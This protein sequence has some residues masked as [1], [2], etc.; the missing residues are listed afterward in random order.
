MPPTG[1]CCGECVQKYCV[2]TTPNGETKLLNEGESV[3]SPNDNCTSYKC[4]MSGE[5]LVTVEQKVTCQVN[6][7]ADCKVDEEYFRPANHCCGECVKKSCGFVMPN[8]DLLLLNPGETT[9]DT[10]DICTNYTCK[11]V[12]GQLIPEIEKQKCK[13]QSAADCQPGENYTAPVDACC[14]KC[15]QN[16]CIIT[17]PSGEIAVLKP[18][19]SSSSA[20]DKCVTYECIE[21]GGALYTMLHNKS[22]DNVTIEDCETGTIEVSDDGCCSKCK[23]PK[24]CGVDVGPVVLLTGECP[25][26]LTIPFCSGVCMNPTM[27]NAMEP[28]CKC[29]QILQSSKASEPVAC[30]NGTTIIYEYDLI[31]KCGCHDPP[32]AYSTTPR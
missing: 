16:E 6:S 17:M 1:Q 21:V 7:S 3:S 19:E 18:G 9:T 29:C 13:I 28:V 2:M 8:G 32:C 25:L 30:K 11:E 31:E 26:T 5:Q 4:V 15:V 12:N 10:H 22:C 27:P 24:P 23:A 20:K 14:G